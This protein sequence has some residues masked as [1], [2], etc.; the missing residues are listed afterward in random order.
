MAKDNNDTADVEYAP[1]VFGP[2]HESPGVE[3][4]RD[5]VGSLHAAISLVNIDYSNTPL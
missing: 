5:I 2:C 1:K 4:F 3:Q